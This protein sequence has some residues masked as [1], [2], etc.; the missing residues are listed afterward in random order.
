MPSISSFLCFVAV[1]L[2]MVGKV[3]CDLV[4]HGRHEL[5]G[6][7]ITTLKGNTMMA[8]SETDLELYNK[9]DGACNVT[10]DGDG[11]ILLWYDE[12]LKDNGCSLDLV[13]KNDNIFG[14]TFTIS[15]NDM[16]T[17]LTFSSLDNMMFFTFSLKNDEFEKLKKDGHIYGKNCNKSSRYC[18]NIKCLEVYDYAIGWNK[19]GFAL[20]LIGDPIVLP[21]KPISSE[22]WSPELSFGREHYLINK[23]YEL[24]PMC[25]K[26]DT[27]REPKGWKI[28][29]NN[30]Y[31]GT[32]FKYLL[33]FHILPVTK[34]RDKMEDAFCK[35]DYAIDC[36]GNHKMQKCAKMFVKFGKDHYKLLVPYIPTTT[37]NTST[38]QKFIS[39]T[40][41]KIVTTSF[42]W[43]TTKTTN[44]SSTT[45]T[46]KQTSKT[47]E[48]LIK[49]IIGFCLIFFVSIFSC[50][51]VCCCV[52]CIKSKKKNKQK[53]KS[54]L[55][56]HRRSNPSKIHVSK[57]NPPPIQL[58]PPPIQAN[59]PPVRANPNLIKFKK[60]KM[61][62]VSRPDKL[63]FRDSN[64]DI[65]KIKVVKPPSTLTKTDSPSTED[66]TYN[67]TLTN[68]TMM[69]TYKEP[70]EKVVDKD[71]DESTI[72]K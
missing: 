60:S 15:D 69:W 70:P 11:N 56:K 41:T 14:L 48:N 71:D 55:D 57:P 64:E 51:L 10:M 50:F 61:T 54:N 35:K 27:R 52:Y 42:G 46:T 24:R 32:E 17:C 12:K 59:P 9:M 2:L 67:Q 72:K 22:V 23:I 43:N 49:F 26:N 1:V 37:V 39:T 66:Y 34:M 4:G 19:V 38:T 40:T 5:D 8:E 65:A 62:T 25:S 30:Y 47:K 44:Y 33:T 29:D 63:P 58:N 36:S 6:E 7:E 28:V 45:L 13:T 18:K 20:H 31:K 21:S 16:L 3:N 53:P 68:Q